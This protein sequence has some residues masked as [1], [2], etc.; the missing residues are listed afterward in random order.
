MEADDTD[1]STAGVV[2]EACE[3]A[4]TGT[5]TAGSA[6]FREA[7]AGTTGAGVAPVR[8]DP[9][10]AVPED[11]AGLTNR[12]SG[13]VGESLFATGAVSDGSPGSISMEL[14][15]PAIGVTALERRWWPDER[16]T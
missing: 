14:P 6:T 2:E 13:T 7:V 9:A 11:A 5:T 12:R 10:F 4:G 1:P 16:P 3:E 8:V 15:P